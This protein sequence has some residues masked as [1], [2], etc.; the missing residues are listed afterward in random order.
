M[1]LVLF[2]TVFNFIFDHF[3][4]IRPRKNQIRILVLI[5]RTWMQ[6]IVAKQHLKKKYN[7]FFKSI[8]LSKGPPDPHYFE[9]R[10]NMFFFV[11]K[12]NYVHKLFMDIQYVQESSIKR[13]STVE[14]DEKCSKSDSFFSVCIQLMNLTQYRFASFFVLDTL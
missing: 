3:F 2:W 14:F 10:R 5:V 6:K 8:F 7:F 12:L 1:K 4:W 13:Y 9:V 11:C